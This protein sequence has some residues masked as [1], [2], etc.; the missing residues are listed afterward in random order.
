MP[1]S[2]QGVLLP[3]LANSHP[4]RAD[5]YLALR[6]AVL[7]GTLARGER[8]PSSRKAATD[9][10]VS[11]GLME[12]V[13]AQLVDEG[14]LERVVGRGTFI[15]ERAVK[16]TDP[17]V[18]GKAPQRVSSI[19][20]RGLKLAGN[21]ACRFTHE[22][23]PFNAGVADTTAFPWQIWQ[24]IQARA[25]RDLRRADMNFTD[26]R[27]LPALRQSLAHHLAQLRGV[28]CVPEQVIIFNSIQQASYLLALL[29]TNPGDAAWVEDPG[30]PGTRAALE[31]AGAAIVHVPV[32]RQGLQVEEGL[33]RAPHARLAC[34]T[35]SHQF[36]CGF[37]MSA[38]RRIA[39]LEWAQKHEAWILEDD[40]DG[41]FGH[42]RQ[43]ATPL[44]SLDQ[45]ARVLY[46]GTLSKSMF[47][48]LRLAF[49]VVPEAMVEQLANIRTQLDAFNAPLIQLA[50]SRFMDEGHFSTHVRHMRNVYAEKAAVLTEGLKPL[51]NHGWT[52]EKGT[53]GLQILL[54][55]PNARQVQ[56]TAEASGLE[57]HLLNSYRHKPAD[58][59]GL[60]LR[61]GG[62][63]IPA[64]HLGVERLVSVAKSNGGS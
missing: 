63:S 34:V 4:R 9:Y 47:V 64:I 8:M 21:L 31:L 24:R 2:S 52:W 37:A 30:Y 38:E 17:A 42:A 26:P 46:L 3:P 5:V 60:L 44:H 18:N 39:L 36:P 59:D 20:T 56:R 54:R 49:A 12:E 43:P 62:L 15:A 32:D 53:A 19:S 6:D 1:R 16:R 35:P 7:Q 28:R 48:S 40:Y 41:E 27:G 11:R 22:F 10:G 50:M 14:L 33:R 25:V 45:H 13:Y 23:K 51:A 55:H 58:D 61:F 29:L 57:V